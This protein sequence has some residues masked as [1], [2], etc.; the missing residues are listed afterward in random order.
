MKSKKNFVGKILKT[1]DGS[2]QGKTHI[3]KPRRV[4]VVYQR[5]DGCIGVCKVFGSESLNDKRKGLRLKPTTQNGLTKKSLAEYRVYFGA[6]RKDGSYHAFSYENFT[7]SGS[8]VRPLD[9]FKIRIALLMKPSSRRIVKA[10]K[11]HFV[12]KTRVH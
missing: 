4:I 5:D 3:K 9:V 7:D 10:W 6:K 12:R 2:L 1:T 11:R 8:R